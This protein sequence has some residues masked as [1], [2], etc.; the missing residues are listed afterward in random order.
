MGQKLEYL[1]DLCILKELSN[2]KRMVENEIRKFVKDDEGAHKDQ[3]T[4]AKKRILRKGSKIASYIKQYNFKVNKALNVGC[5]GEPSKSASVPYFDSGYDMIGVDVSE[6]YLKYFSKAFNT[7]AVYANALC[8]PFRDGKF[9]LVN[10]TD[11]LEHLTNP[12]HGLTEVHRV[13]APGGII[14]LST[15]NRNV[16]EI[17]SINPI[18]LAT[19]MVGTYC[20]SILPH[21][22]DIIADWMGCQFYHTAFARRELIKLMK[23]SGFQILSI[24]TQ[25]TSG[26]KVVNLLE[27]IPVLKFLCHD[28]MVVGQKKMNI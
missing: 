17:R 20:E 3:F 4:A 1:K 6:E 5:G 22:R 13:L 8:L 16:L 19:Q 7:D 21:S 23:A 9:D 11:I 25:N 18:I 27:Y 28:F 26:Y 12:I 15:P 14:I 10:F 2:E 24:E